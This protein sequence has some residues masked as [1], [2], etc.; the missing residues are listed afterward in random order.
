MSIPINIFLEGKKGF[1]MRMK[2]VAL[3]IVVFIFV[4]RKKIQ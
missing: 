4:G 3:C 2:H 1:V